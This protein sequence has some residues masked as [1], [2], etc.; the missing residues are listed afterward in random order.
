MIT[1]SITT[2]NVEQTTPIQSPPIIV[3]R[4]NISEDHPPNIIIGDLEQR[5]MRQKD[6][7][8]YSKLACFYCFVSNIEPK[9]VHEP[10]QMIIR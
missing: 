8:D 10:L 6:Q 5:T 1:K 4:K 3:V 7:I 9:N 2:E